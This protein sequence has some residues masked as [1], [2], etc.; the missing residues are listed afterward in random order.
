M[1]QEQADRRPRLLGPALLVG[2]LLGAA[3]V[4]S[5]QEAADQRLARSSVYL[6][7]R[8]FAI[9]FRLNNGGVSRVVLWASTDDRFFQ[10]VGTANPKDKEFVYTAQKDGWHYFVVQVEDYAGKKDPV[11]VG[12][13]HVQSQVCV[14][15][16]PPKI[17]FKQVRPVEGSVGVEWE[18]TDDHQLNLKL[19]RVEYRAAKGDGRWIALPIKPLPSA[20]I[21]WSPDAGEYEARVVAY[22]MAGHST[23]A[24]TTVVVK[25]GPGP[26]PDAPRP[27][28]DADVKFVPKKT[29]K[30]QYK[31]E[32]EGPSS[33]KNVEVWMTRDKDKSWGLF[34]EDAPANPGDGYPITVGGTGRYGFTLRPVSGVG[35][36][37]RAPAL[38]E[39]PQIWVEVD[40]TPPE[41]RIDGVTVGEGADDGFITVNW[42]AA[43]K[44]LK[45]N[46]ITIK[47]ATADAKDNWQVLQPNLPHT[48][49]AR[50]STAPLGKAYEFYLR[51]E[52]QD[53]AGNVGHDQTKDTVK[54]DT[55]EP[56]VT[57]IRVIGVGP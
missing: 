33:I 37:A 5:A 28:G 47:Y 51:V 30:L 22:D 13:A 23:E 57:G 9:P 10:V 14:D 42:T 46:G 54:V 31:V 11:N 52:A 53:E 55:K 15:G 8:K 7:D 44:W 35:R 48:R 49:T 3:V 21:G 34:K 43:D 6:K 41:V 56:K 27:R 40:E 16:V 26:A 29:F 24:K 18:V 1:P 50:I 17:D 36:A 12:S 39:A 32:D 38:G 19:L 25:A 20:H 4:A 2:L 45:P